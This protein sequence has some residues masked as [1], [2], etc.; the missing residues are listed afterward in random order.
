[1]RIVVVGAG[2]IGMEV[3]ASARQMGADVTVLEA[4]E[5][6]LARCLPASVGQWLRSVHEN[7]GCL[8]HTGVQVNAI[9]Q[10]ASGLRVEASRNDGALSVAADLVLIAIGIDCSVDFLRDTDI[11]SPH[12]VPIDANC[13]SPVAPWC[14][15]VG[16]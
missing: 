16:D 3:A 12:G 4:G 11:A 6:V 7:H 13:T 15:A 10:E 9:T 14:F 2:V 1:G 5:N 8:I